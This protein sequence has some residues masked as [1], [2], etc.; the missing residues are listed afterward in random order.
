MTRFWLI[1]SPRGITVLVLRT[2]ACAA[3]S[4][5]EASSVLEVAGDDIVLESTGVDI[6]LLVAVCVEVN[7][8]DILCA[9][10]ATLLLVGSCDAES[11]G[12][13]ALSSWGGLVG[14]GE[15]S[16][17]GQLEERRM[18]YVVCV[19]EGRERTKAE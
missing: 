5:V 10:V 18:E 3:G 11:V 12:R 9:V 19:K 6:L 15:V 4:S 7:V 16:K 17:G 8:C 14:S 13:E 2:F 1:I